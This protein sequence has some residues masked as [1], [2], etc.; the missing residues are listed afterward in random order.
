LPSD[1]RR[2][3]DFQVPLKLIWALPDLRMQGLRPTPRYYRDCCLCRSETGSST[4]GRATQAGTELGYVSSQSVKAIW[5][6]QRNPC[7]LA[8]DIFA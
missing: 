4:T 3:F 1:R 7:H 6:Q 5:S 2:N 8:G